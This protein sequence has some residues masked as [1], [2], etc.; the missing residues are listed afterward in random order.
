MSLKSV[1]TYEVEA[2]GVLKPVP[3]FI[4]QTD[5][6]G[7]VILGGKC[8]EI[9]YDSSNS[10]GIALK[11]DAFG[12]W[13][14]PYADFGTSSA[15]GA[16]SCNVIKDA[17]ASLIGAGQN[18]YISGQTTVCFIK[19]GGETLF[20]TESFGTKSFIGAGAANKICSPKS[21]II[22]GHGN[23][24]LGTTCYYGSFINNYPT[25]EYKC[26]NVAFAEGEWQPFNI[27]NGPGYNVVAGGKNNYLNGI[28]S[29]I[30]GGLC[31]SITSNRGL[32][33]DGYGGYY[34]GQLSGQYNFL[35]GGFSNLINN[36]CTATI[37]GGNDNTIDQSNNSSI[38]GGCRNVISGGNTDNNSLVGG[39]WNNILGGAYQFMGGGYRN[40]I[41]GASFS[42]L[43]GGCQNSIISSNIRG[44]ASDQLDI[45]VGGVLNTISGC[46][47][48]ILG[49][50]TNYIQ[51]SCNSILAGSQNIIK[52]SSCVTILA[53]Y[54]IS[55]IHAG[56]TIVGDQTNRFKTSDG[57]NMLTIDF[58]SGITLKSSAAPVGIYSYGVSGQ[59]AFDKNYLY[60][61]N[62]D[63]W[64]RTAMSTW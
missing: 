13:S 30:G 16:G 8:S 37:A 59:V 14:G 45:I 2:N 64:T 20:K 15:I 24:V 6:T 19:V 57:I 50:S 35:G 56:S 11:H 34:I 42:A 12:Y 33:P 17:Q 22:G 63:Y 47:N 38:V 40:L 52:N 43:V 32:I 26:Y 55:G 60:R 53:G 10:P 29:I 46:L 51:G 41:S 48:T 25:D 27:S 49:G 5:T 44:R 61:H 62:G 3:N 21:A 1:Q 36:S 18:N 58:A 54:K 31:N 28:F 23:T 7:S 4:F 39:F 9:L